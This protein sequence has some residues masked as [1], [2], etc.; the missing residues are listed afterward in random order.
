MSQARTW[1]SNATY[2]GIGT[3]ICPLRAMHFL[4]NSDIKDGKDKLMSAIAACA[5]Q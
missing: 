5:V 2:R 1:I 3:Q 4:Y